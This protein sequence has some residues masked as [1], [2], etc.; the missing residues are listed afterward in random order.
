MVGIQVYAVSDINLYSDHT[1][2]Y[3]TGQGGWIQTPVSLTSGEVR[4]MRTS[5]SE[6][7]SGSAGGWTSGGIVKLTFPLPRP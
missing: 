4:R 7:P 1:P 2:S 6:A 5:P 3:A